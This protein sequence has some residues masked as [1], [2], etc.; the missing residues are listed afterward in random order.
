MLARTRTFQIPNV[1]NIIL[2]YDTAVTI[3]IALMNNWCDANFSCIL[4][5]TRGVHKIMHKLPSITPSR[6]IIHQFFWIN[7]ECSSS[8][9]AIHNWIER[10]F[11]Q[12]VHVIMSLDDVTLQSRWLGTYLF[13]IMAR[14]IV[15]VDWTKVIDRFEWHS[16]SIQSIMCDDDDF[17]LFIH[18]IQCYVSWMMMTV[19]TRIRMSMNNWQT[20]HS[21]RQKVRNRDNDNGGRLSRPCSGNW[22]GI[23][24]SCFLEHVM[25]SLSKRVLEW[26]CHRHYIRRQTRI[27]YNLSIRGKM[28]G[29]NATSWIIL[30]ESLTYIPMR[31]SVAFPLEHLL[32]MSRQ[33]LSCLCAA[34]A[35]R[36][37][38]VGRH[39]CGQQMIDSRKTIAKMRRGATSNSR[40]QLINM[41]L[42]LRMMI[43]SSNEM[44]ILVCVCV[45]CL[46]CL[47]NELRF[48]CRTEFCIW[49]VVGTWPTVTHSFRMEKKMFPPELCAN[50]FRTP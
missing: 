44:K 9:H 45:C 19:H 24:C 27:I 34:L 32:G 11:G 8:A 46:A 17:Q 30:R 35:Y 23:V 43:I 41:T 14:S 2:Y 3:S 18:A 5:K 49:L 50:I 38:Y 40:M 6:R 33:S 28:C 10:L 15:H 25:Y 21:T 20:V 7:Q 37:F 4:R 31:N 1:L 48:L 42:N 13:S 26:L 36:T 29:L 22:Y 12:D 39:L 47:W 16:D